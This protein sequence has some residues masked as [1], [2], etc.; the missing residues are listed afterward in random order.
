MFNQK[1]RLADKL[2]GKKVDGEWVF[3]NL[4]NGVYYG[5]NETGSLI[6]DELAS[7]KKPEMAMDRLQRVFEIDPSTAEKDVK[8]FVAQLKKEGVI[9]V[10][11]S[12]A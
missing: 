4:N 3:L 8:Q 10:E 12:S 5:L 9:E 7:G 2:I 1:I 6:W 11:S